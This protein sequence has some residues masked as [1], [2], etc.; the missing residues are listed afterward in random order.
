MEAGGASE[1]KEGR[2]GPVARGPAAARSVRERRESAREDWEG[3]WWRSLERRAPHGLSPSTNSSTL[4]Q[5]SGPPIFCGGVC[6]VDHLTDDFLD[7]NLMGPKP[8]IDCAST[9]DPRFYIWGPG[10]HYTDPLCF[11]GSLLFNIST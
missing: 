10:T 1:R 3:R 2:E 8:A 7:W 5:A 6:W 9:L 4:E 11:T